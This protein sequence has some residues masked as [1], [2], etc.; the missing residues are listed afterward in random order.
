MKLYMTPGSCSTGIHIIMEELE[1]AFEAHIVNL[2]AGDH[3]KP[4]YVAVNPKSTIPALVRPDGTALT[5]VVSIAYWLART[6]GR[7]R[8][9][10]A[11][12]D[13]ETQALETM[14]YVVSTVHGQGF[15]RIFATPS[16]AAG[17]D[18]QKRV[19]MLGRDI[20]RQGFAILDTALAGRDYVVGAFSAADAVLFY[21][22]FWA[23]KTGIELP[24]NLAAHYWRM[25]ER[26]VVQRVLREEG[27]NLT[28][29][30]AQPTRPH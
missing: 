25:L 22:E 16:F 30:G 2:P 26:P 1:E 28:L 3:F 20:V 24:A 8:L 9:W 29:L 14:V 5:E 6:R 15:A 23:D 4:D 19:E 18:D 17:A 27:Y 12:A 10:P 21:V 11:D 13:A 7:G